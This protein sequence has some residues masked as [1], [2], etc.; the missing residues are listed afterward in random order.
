MPDDDG[1]LA[2]LPMFI[3]EKLR[4]VESARVATSTYSHAG[5]SVVDE[6]CLCRRFRSRPEK[7]LG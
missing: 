6:L 7:V 1:G 5:D 2:P 3:P 4:D